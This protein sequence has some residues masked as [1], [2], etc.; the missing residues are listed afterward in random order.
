MRAFRTF[1]ALLAG[2]AA[3]CSFPAPGEPPPL[4][5]RERWVYAP[6][7]LG[8][9]RAV[10]KL[11]SLISRAARAGYNAFLLE[12][13]NFGKLPLMSPAY[14][15]HLER[16]KRA[17]SSHGV[18]LIPALFQIG[19]S[20]NLLAQDPNLAEGLPVRDA[21]FVVRGGTARLEPDPPV[22]LRPAWDWKD[23]LVG[24]DGTVRD[25]RGR[26]ARMVQKLAV[27]PFRQYHVSVRVR[28]RQFQGT[29]R[30]LVVGK[31]RLLNYRFLGVRPTQDWTEHH[32]FFNSLDS[33]EIR[34]Y[35]GCWDGQTG[36]LAWAQPRLRE[37]GLFNLLRR[38]GAPL[39]VRTEDG[40]LLLEGRDFEP[41]SDPGL[42][43]ILERRSYDTWH[44]PPVLRTSLPDGTRLRVSYYHAISMPD[45]GQTMICPSEPRTLEI[46]RDQARRLHRIFRPR[47]F[48]MTHDEVRV[49]NWDESCRR[50][51]LTPAQI[52][53]DNVRSCIGFLREIDPRAEIYVW[54]D[55]WDPYHNARPHYALVN[56]D[57]T[58][59]WEGLDR[60]V[61]VAD[62]YFDRREESLRW[63][64]S[65][66]HR[67]LLAAYYDKMPER[68]RDWIETARRTG[69]AVG[70]MYT[71]W[72]DK[73]EDLETFARH[74]D[75]ALAAP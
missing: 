20:Q 65:R 21:L 45:H 6:F 22:S 15:A 24:D 61:I 52:L 50:R 43:E 30:V 75:A 70:I 58:G 66:G 39:S 36:E 31:G 41:V 32:A 55:M 16:V 3:G 42:A 71:S 9:A 5:L 1:A 27:R 62:W 8:D 46:L 4:R 63:F 49:L 2:A 40:R 53:A 37:I 74:V 44:E 14:Y 38:P 11:E 23:A 12:D 18:D 48:F 47:A 7:D 59:S 72:F 54:S 29:P 19:H 34:L 64:A 56:G 17:A 13:P 10:E 35:L 51:N 73:Y 26:Y 60:D 33:S 25:P 68:A 67:T 28:T 57:L 69:G